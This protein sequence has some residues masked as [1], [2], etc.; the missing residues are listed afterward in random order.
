MT[1][2][3]IDWSKFYRYCG[4]G[5][6]PFGSDNPLTDD[7]RMHRTDPRQ[8]VT[9]TLPAG[10]HVSLV[11]SFRTTPA[12]RAGIKDGDVIVLGNTSQGWVPVTGFGVAHGL[13]V[14]PVGSPVDL[15]VTTPS[16]PNSLRLVTI[17]KDWIVPIAKDHPIRTIAGWENMVAA[18]LFNIPTRSKED[19]SCELLADI[20]P[21][22]LMTLIPPTRTAFATTPARQAAY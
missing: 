5:V 9:P 12:Q 8:I 15:Q 1:D 4:S 7:F 11:H 16:Q 22:Q 17:Q 6:M 10:Y 14:G 21:S 3:P 13:L 20:A 2:T 19:D 18:N